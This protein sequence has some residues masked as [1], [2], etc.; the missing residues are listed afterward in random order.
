MA[1]MFKVRKQPAD[2]RIIKMRNYEDRL[3]AMQNKCAEQV[4][5]ILMLQSPIFIVS[6]GFLNSHSSVELCF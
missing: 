6:L 3:K 4:R 1:E 2:A 5:A